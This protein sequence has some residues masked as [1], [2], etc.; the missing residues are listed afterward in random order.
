MACGCFP[1]ITHGARIEDGWVAGLT[2]GLALGE[3]HVEGDEGGIRLR[4]PIIGPFVGYGNAPAQASQP[5]FYIGAAV[6]VFFPLAQIDA[7]AQLPP[8]WTGSLALGAGAVASSEG[9]TGYALMG[10]DLNPA[11]AWHIGAGYGRRTSSSRF[12]SSSPAWVGS[13]GIEMA[14]GYLRTQL[15]VQ[16]AVGN[17]PGSC[18]DDPVSHRSTC[19]RGENAN[20]A[21]LGV[22]VGRH[23]KKRP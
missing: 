10:G 21:A 8:A 7:Y 19:T 2:G 17:R 9:V 18:F 13:A 14:S 11:S 20:A 6:P 16:A 12:Q 3:T 1:A 4:Q 5:R 22:T 23:Q 15:F